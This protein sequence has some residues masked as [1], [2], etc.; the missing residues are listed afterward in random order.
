MK[1]QGKGVYKIATRDQVFKQGSHLF[2]KKKLR[3]FQGL[4]RTHFSF[5]KDSNQSKKEP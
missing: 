4:S 2:L 1:F 5:F 3:T